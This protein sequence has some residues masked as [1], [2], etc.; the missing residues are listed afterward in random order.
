MKNLFMKITNDIDNQIEKA[1]NAD[2]SGNY[3]YELHMNKHT[4]DFLVR[5]SAELYGQQVDTDIDHN[6]Y[7]I[8]KVVVDNHMNDYSASVWKVMEHE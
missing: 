1:T 2:D 3:R 5:V 7:K 6:H 4:I 8:C